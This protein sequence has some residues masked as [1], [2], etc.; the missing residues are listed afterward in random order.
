MKHLTTCNLLK[1][2]RAFCITRQE[3]SMS[4]ASEVLYA[5]QPTIS[6]QIKTLEQELGVK[7]FER[8]GP[9][10]KLTTEGEI[11]YDLVSPL[12][13]GIDHI[14]E[15]FAAHYGD[16]TTGELTIAAEESTILYTLP[17][18]IRKFIEL[19]PGIRLKLANVTGHDGRE[20]LLAD[21][22][23]FAVSSM[24]DVPDNLDYAPF[25]SYPSVLIMP[26]GH[27]L[28]KLDKVTLADIGQYGMILPPSQF[29][30]WRLVKMVFALNGASYHIVLEAGGWEVVKRYVGIGLGISIVTNICITEEDQER[31]DIVN[32][33]DYFPA[34]KYGVVS[35]SGKALSA[36]AQRF[37]EILNDHYKNNN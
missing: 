20:M 34:R 28:S 10:L 17:G 19:H 6:L 15:S 23:D 4:K 2:L 5:S 8:R 7:L 14:K 25:V 24:L 26:K 27:P 3:G 13:Q 33:D 16:L 22:V 9:R 21:E 32:L 31:F 35:R 12:V 1:E 29:S 18:P 37:I 30:S 11:L 36:P